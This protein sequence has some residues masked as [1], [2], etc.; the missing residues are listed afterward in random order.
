MKYGSFE[1]IDIA[2]AVEEGLI[3]QHGLVSP[4]SIWKPMADEIDNM[5]MHL[6]GVASVHRVPNE[7]VW[8]WEG[9]ATPH[10]VATHLRKALGLIG[11]TSVIVKPELPPT[12][13]G[14]P[15]PEDGLP[16]IEDDLPLTP[17]EAARVEIR[18]LI[19]EHEVRLAHG[20]KGGPGMPTKTVVKQ[21]MAIANNPGNDLGFSDPSGLVAAIVGQITGM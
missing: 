1:E 7:M 4:V 17:T 5:T 21:I 20:K 15:G 12:E 19:K 8:R 2:L 16:G 14:L 13:E 3:T 11:Y 10:E 18:R 6:D 9:T